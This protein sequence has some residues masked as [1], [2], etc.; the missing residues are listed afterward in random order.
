MTENE[1]LQLKKITDDLNKRMA[2]YHS[3]LEPTNDEVTIAWLL[4]VIA[5]LQSTI[6]FPF[7]TKEV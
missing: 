6:E 1:K 7:M 5:E 2:G 4:T 3:S